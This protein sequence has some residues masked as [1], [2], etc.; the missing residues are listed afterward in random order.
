MDNPT[1]TSPSN[2][3]PAALEKLVAANPVTTTTKPWELV[4]TSQVLKVRM[5][6]AIIIVM[7]VH[8]F[9]AFAV[10]AGDT[11]AKV[12]IVDQFAFTGIG[13]VFSAGLLLM[14]RPRVRVNADGVEVR[15]FLGSQF[16][17]WSLVYGL[18]FPKGDHWARLELPDFEFVSMMAFQA[19]DKERVMKAVADFRALE[20]K[21]MPED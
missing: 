16:Y 9:M 13:L 18:S 12:D 15:N 14:L 20:D 4:V 19:G 7:L 5:V 6:I 11:G 3:P 8:I 1:S 2:Q 17:P 21:Y 10:V